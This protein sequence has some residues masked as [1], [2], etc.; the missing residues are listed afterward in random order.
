MQTPKI[1]PSPSWF[2]QDEKK[3]IEI[4]F[5]SINLSTQIAAQGNTSYNHA[6]III[7]CMNYFTASFVRLADTVKMKD[8]RFEAIKTNSVCEP[9]SLSARHTSC[10]TSTQQLM[11]LPNRSST[12]L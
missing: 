10:R 11:T 9:V 12:Q 6:S 3:S 5:F 4:N 7:V 2:S 1:I 8:K